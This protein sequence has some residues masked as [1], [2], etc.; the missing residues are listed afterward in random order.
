VVRKNASCPSKSVIERYSWDLELD[1]VVMGEVSTKGILTDM[2]QRRRITDS[3]KKWMK[4]FLRKPSVE[5]LFTCSNGFAKETGLIELVGDAI[6]A[7][8]SNNG[9]AAM[10]MLGK[11]VFAVN[12]FETLKEFGEPFKARIDC[13]GVRK[14]DSSSGSVQNRRHGKC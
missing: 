2:E 7:V 12:G 6:E 4:E 11:T 1:F 14:I 9:M 10:V 3:G 13:C 8:E 5:N